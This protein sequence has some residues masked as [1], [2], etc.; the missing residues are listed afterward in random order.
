VTAKSTEMRVTEVDRGQRVELLLDGEPVSGLVINDLQMRIGR[1]VVHM[2]GIGGVHTDRKHRMKGY[3]RQVMEYSN[4]YMLEAGYDVS[5]LFGISNFYPKFGFIS[6]LPTYRMTLTT[7][8]VEHADSAGPSARGVKVRRAREKDFARIRTIYNEHNARRT[9]SVVRPRNWARFRKGSTWGV[10][11]LALVAADGRDRVVA[12]AG[13]DGRD[14]AVTVFEVGGAAK[15]YP[16]LLGSL[17]RQAVRKRCE[18]IS[19]LFPPDDAFSLYARQFG[20][21]LEVNYPHTGGGMLR[22]IN[23]KTTFEKLLPELSA[24]LAG[25]ALSG[26]STTLVLNTDLGTIRLA[27]GPGKVALVS[28]GGT[29]RSTVTI[30]QCF[31]SRLLFGYQTV[32]EVSAEPG[33]RVPGGVKDLLQVLF[34]LQWAHVSR[35]DWF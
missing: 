12:Y 18:S 31:L 10:K 26:E 16:A 22:I 19:F 8:V 34:P 28:R 24:R 21:R 14:D 6:C 25:S 33:V 23:L 1:A 30:P 27:A 4:T 17:A 11:P 9:G 35:P 3:S 13:Y 7:R 5:L 2:G 15:A 29:R 32:E 20:G